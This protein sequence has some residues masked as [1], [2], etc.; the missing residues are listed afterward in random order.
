HRRG[1]VS[2]RSLLRHAARQ[3]DAA[4][5]PRAGAARAGRCSVERDARRFRYGVAGAA[6]RGLQ[7]VA[8]EGAESDRQEAVGGAKC[9]T[10]LRF[11]RD[12]T[13]L[14]GPIPL[15]SFSSTIAPARPRS[16]SSS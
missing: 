4:A 16:K 5:R 9:R 13:F 11:E 3:N 1:G 6:A 8:A 15:P 10:K 12:A 2:V 14:P 7:V